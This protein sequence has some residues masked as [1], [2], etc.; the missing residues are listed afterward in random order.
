MIV[1]RFPDAGTAKPGMV[2][3]RRD[4]KHCGIIDHK[5]DKFIHN[6]S[7]KKFATGTSLALAKDYFSSGFVYKS[8]PVLK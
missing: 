4:S 6:S 2:I 7:A 8:Y 3:V 5:G 1:N